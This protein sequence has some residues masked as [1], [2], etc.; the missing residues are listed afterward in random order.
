MAVGTAVVYD[1]MDF[2]TIT[3]FS[4]IAKEKTDGKS[5]PFTN[6]NVGRYKKEHALKTTEMTKITSFKDLDVNIFEDDV[7][8][9]NV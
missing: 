9:H 6:V 2:V 5:Y 4:Q 3:I 8:H 1:K 7:T